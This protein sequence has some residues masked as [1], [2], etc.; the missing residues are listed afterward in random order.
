M[1]VGAEPES[2]VTVES[3]PEPDVAV[4]FDSGFVFEPVGYPLGVPWGEVRV[5]RVVRSVVVNFAGD[6]VAD[7][8]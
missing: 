5:E 1:A 4:G 3:G 7:E 6:L 8:S 2:E